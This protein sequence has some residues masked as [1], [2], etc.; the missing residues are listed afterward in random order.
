MKEQH[1]DAPGALDEWLS[2]SRVRHHAPTLAEL[3][4]RRLRDELAPPEIVGSGWPARHVVGPDRRTPVQFHLGQDWAWDSDLRHIALIAGTK[5]GKTSFGPWWM[6]REIMNRG[7]GDYMAVTA[8]FDLFKLKML[9][10]LRLV[11]E[12]ILDIGRY[13]AGDR[14]ME[15]RDP[16]TG[17]FWANRADDLMWARIIL[18]S[19]D[20]K[21]GLESGEAKAAWADEAGQPRFGISAYRALRRRCAP[22]QAPILYTTTLYDLGWCKSELIDAAEK[23]GEKTLITLDNGAELE[24]TVNPE[25]GICLVQCD[26]IANPTYPM[27]EY[28][29]ARETLP[30][31]EFQMFF[32]GRA[33]MLRYL[34]YDSFDREKHTCDRFPIPSDWKRYLGLDFGP[35]HTAGVF[36]A[37]ELRTG[38]LYCYRQYMAGNK[39]IAEHARDLLAGE[40]G[41]PAKTVGGS[42]S[43]KQWRREFAA[44]GLPVA[45]P[46]VKEVGIG[47]NRVYGC[48]KKDEIT[49]FND[50][51]GVI[52][53]KET[54]KKK[55]D[56]QGNVTDEI[57]NKSRFHFMDAERYILGWKKR[58]SGGWSARYG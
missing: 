38:Q 8:T 47:I 50:L 12:N 25:A 13:W 37:E 15:I 48:H 41:R 54:Y 24:R 27:A 17:R 30:D 5:A 31:D 55:R 19:A 39:T 18:R 53:E 3:A 11:F 33:T 14:I 23:G 36:Y 4:L 44:A 10:E 9:P 45:P 42:K 29:E 28:E 1:G 43:E 16:T 34:I 20:A 51:D 32:R 21:G 52:R 56:R 22:Y 58:T 6:H 57:A 46:D 7:A 49:Y 2:M 35:V 40:P 26:S